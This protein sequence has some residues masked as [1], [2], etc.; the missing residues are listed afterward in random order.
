MGPFRA[1]L[2][3]GGV[4]WGPMKTGFFWSQRA[5]SCPPKEKDRRILLEPEG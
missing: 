3:R 2:I 4:V 5:E 1:F